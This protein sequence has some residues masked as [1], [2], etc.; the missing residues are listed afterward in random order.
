MTQW[1]YGAKTKAAGCATWV[2][3]EGDLITAMKS[4]CEESEAVSE[5]GVVGCCG[6]FAEGL[7]GD[8]LR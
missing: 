3:I 5:G 6:D 7:S 8:G 2:A 4:Y 1:W